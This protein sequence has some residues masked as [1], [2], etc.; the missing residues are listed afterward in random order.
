MHTPSKNELYYS[1]LYSM[2][3]YVLCRMRVALSCRDAPQP[4]RL[5]LERSQTTLFSTIS[6]LLSSAA[7]ETDLSRSPL[8]WDRPPRPSVTG[9]WGLCCPSSARPSASSCT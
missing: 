7:V 2:L 1:H 8:T 3:S 5:L 4:V 9:K 6:Q